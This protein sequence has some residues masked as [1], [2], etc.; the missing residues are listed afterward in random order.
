MK[1]KKMFLAVIGLCLTLVPVTAQ[2]VYDAAKIADKD[3]NGTARFVGMGGAMSALG[4]DISTIGTNPAGIGI[5]RSHDVMTS[6]SLSSFGTDANYMGNNLSTSKMKGSYDNLGFVLSTKIGNKTTLRYVNFGFNYHKSNSFYGNMEMGGDLGNQSQSY[7]MAQ[8]AAGIESWGNSPYTDVNIG[9]LSVLGYD[10]W[11]IT[12]ITT[13]KTGTPYLDEDGNQIND[14]NG[15]PLYR[16]PGVYYGLYDNGNAS[17]RSEQRGGIEQYDFN[18]SFNIKDRVY[19]GLTLGAYSV[20]YNK[21]TTY[22]ESYENGEYYSLTSNNQIVGAGF[23]VKVGAIIRPFE[24]SPLRVGLAVHTPTFYSL[25]YKTRAYVESSLYDPVTG[26]NEAASVATENI[27]D[28]DM[29]REF[30]L[31]TPWLYNVSLGY[32][33]GNSWALGAEYEYQD[34]SSM[35]FRDPQGFSDSFE[36]ENSTTA[37]LKGVHTFRAGLEYKVIPQ[38]AIRAGYN[39]RSAL[40]NKDAFKDL[41]INSIQT[42][43]DFSNTQALNNYTVGIGYRGSMFYADLAYKFTSC[44]SDFYPFVNMNQTD[45]VLEITSPEATKVTDSRSQVLLTLGVRF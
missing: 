4:G 30:R 23:D 18:I 29:I 38:F 39:Y 15:N 5:Y 28:G 1:N 11:L 36:F 32:T 16:T 45:N 17:Y 19:L 13:D 41:P 14:V 22:G 21:Y 44:K 26:K 27:V 34:Y 3:L 10:G 35:E 37:M 9:W 42:D 25:D 6:F 33:I 31:Q 2:T 40:F 8:Q 43:T 12:D 20:D 7:Y 24:Y